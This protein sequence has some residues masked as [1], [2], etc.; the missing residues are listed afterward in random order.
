MNI[1]IKVT[2]KNLVKWS[3]FEDWENGASSAPTEHTLSGAGASVAR[4]ATTIKQG[5]YS[6][7]VTR[8]G[9]DT[10]LYH[11]FPDYADFKGHRM[12]FGCWVY[13]TVA[14][15]ARIAI[16]DGVGSTNS[17]YHTG[18]AGWEFL[19]VTH[20]VDASATRIR[21][22]C[23]VNTGNTT[24]YFDG[25]ILVD[26][27]LNYL[28]TSSYFENWSI[29]NRFRQASHR[30]SR[31]P[32]LIIPDSEFDSLGLNI[33]GNVY[34]TTAT[35]ARSSYDSLMQYLSVGEK[36]V[37]LYDDRYIRAF[38]SSKSDDRKAANRVIEFDLK[39]V[40]QI[41]FYQYVQYLRKTQAISSSPTSFTLTVNGNVYS[42]PIINFIAGGS[43]ITS[44]TLENI[45]RGETMT[46]SG[47]VTAANTLVIDGNDLTVLNNAVDE[48]GSFSG[49][50]LRLNPGDNILKFTGS[51]CTI[52]VDWIDRWL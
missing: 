45:T 51:N 33:S 11:D 1:D 35:A 19:T 17:S 6:A 16:S 7:G 10:T 20:N 50:F 24:G 41:P 48:I 26:G 15:R 46:F 37:Y 42:Q 36:D 5:T 3:N 47:T 21:I 23:H 52:K 39:F 13:A 49:D 14:S 27:P 2:P 29:D 25:G 34:G 9:A 32:G 28:D 4:E 31:R 30:V 22:E 18:V 12:T 8:A 44:C 43:N 38:L 40:T